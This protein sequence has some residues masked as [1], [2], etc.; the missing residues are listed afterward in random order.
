MAYDDSGAT[1]VPLRA[2][3]VRG[4]WVVGCA[5]YNTRGLPE[6]QLHTDPALRTR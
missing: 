6:Q 3:E 2:G 5:G 4:Q 1:V